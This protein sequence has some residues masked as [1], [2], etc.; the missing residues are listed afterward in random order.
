MDSA[1]S[2]RPLA[3]AA[4]GLIARPALGTVSSGNAPE[5]IWLAQAA[6]ATSKPSPIFAA[7]I[8]NSRRAAASISLFGRASKRSVGSR[9]ASRSGSR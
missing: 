6:T 9:S 5:P 8:G 2:R 1:A 3:L 7:M 4:R